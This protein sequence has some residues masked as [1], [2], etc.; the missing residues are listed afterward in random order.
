M[1]I[2]AEPRLVE[3][4]IGR[5]LAAQLIAQGS[6]QGLRF[7]RIAADLR[8]QEEG[9]VLTGHEAD[10]VQF[11]VVK[12]RIAADGRPAGAIERGK[13]AAL[14]EGNRPGLRVFDGRE[15]F[16]Q[17]DVIRPHG[18][19]DNA[20]PGRRHHDLGLDDRGGL[21]GQAEPAQAGQGQQAA[22][23]F[24]G[25]HAAQPGLD[26]AADDAHRQVRAEME[27]LRL[28]ADGGGA[29]HRALGQRGKGGCG[30]R[31]RH[32]RAQDQDVA[33]VF[34]LQRAGEDDAGRKLGLQILQAMDREIDPPIGQCF[35]NF[36]CKQSLAA[37]FGK[38]LVENAIARGHDDVL[39]EHI[40]RIQH[41]AEAAELGLEG[42]G[43]GQRERRSACTDTQ[44]QRAAV[45]FYA[46]FMR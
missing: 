1:A 43:L 15:E 31:L 11:T 36:F 27:K 14:G 46:R 37:H 33:R 12:A 13:Q 9:P 38:P 35:V 44:G 39:F 29:D 10:Q 32:I 19:A 42:P 4:D 20:L 24:A 30:V 28:P 17:F 23:E 40:H 5:G 34:P 45:G 26:I 8:F 16:A 6:A 22:V 41:R 2:G 21:L 7:A 18:H 3:K 25:F